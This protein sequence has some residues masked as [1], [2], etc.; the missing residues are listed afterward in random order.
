M[1]AF[2]CAVLTSASIIASSASIADDSSAMLAAGGIQ[3]TKA[4]EIRMAREDLYLSPKQVRIRYEFANDSGKDIDTLVAF[5]MPDI[6]QW[7][8]YEE[9]IGT[10]GNDPVNFMNFKVVADGR[11]VPV[12]V[13]QRAFVDSRDVTDIVKSVGLPVDVL[14][15]GGVDKIDHLAP[16]RKKILEKAGIA[17]ADAPDQEHPKWLVRTK[18]YWTQHFPAGKTIVIEHSYVPVTGQ[19]FFS[20]YDLN[21]KQAAEGGGNSWQTDYCMDNGTLSAI[22]KLLAAPRPAGQDAGLLNIYSTGFILKTANN[23]KGG[24]GTLHLTV[25]KLK[26][27]NIMSMCWASDLEKT[28]PTTF[29]STLTNFQPKSDI[30]FVVLE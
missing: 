23:W 24:I 14:V 30:K 1:R 5:P 7:N 15:G 27:T 21:P 9:P 25:D 28:G 18:F 19:T 8:F 20:T 10:V 13:E 12:Q 11:N 6:D 22:R 3:F 29:E 17:E 2:I 26:P 4:P 16:A